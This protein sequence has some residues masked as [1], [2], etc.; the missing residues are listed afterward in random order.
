MNMT[1]QKSFTVYI[2]N[3]EYTAMKKN[4]LPKARTN[5]TL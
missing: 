3:F 5:T 2:N 4:N 1:L